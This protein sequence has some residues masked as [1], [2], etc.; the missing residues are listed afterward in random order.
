MSMAAAL[1]LGAVAVP[2]AQAG[3]DPVY[4]P[5]SACPG[6]FVAYTDLPGT[7]ATAVGRFDTKYTVEL[8]Y[9]SYVKDTADDGLDVHLWVLYGKW[10]GAKQTEPIAVASGLNAK[11]EVVWESPAGVF[12]DWFQVRVCLGPGEDNCSRWVG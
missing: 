12:V 1:T 4:D 5:G 10:N 6:K 8:G 3:C 7:E 9:P 2:T 11:T